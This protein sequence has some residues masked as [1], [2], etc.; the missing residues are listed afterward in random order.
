LSCAL[1]GKPD[2]TTSKAAAP[3]FNASQPF[4]ANTP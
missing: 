4:I 3:S 1:V 2:D